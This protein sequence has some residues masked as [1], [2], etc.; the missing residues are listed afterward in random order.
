MM[1]KFKRFFFGRLFPC[2]LTLTFAAAVFLFLSLFLP[3]ALL[4]AFAVERAFTA[5]VALLS[6]RDDELPEERT[7]WLVLMLLLPWTGA[8]ARLL[9]G[10][11]PPKPKIGKAIQMNDD[12]LSSCASIAS[13]SNLFPARYRFAKYFPFGKDA[14]CSYLNDLNEAKKYIFLEYYII[15]PG[16]FWDSVLKILERKAKNGVTVKLIFDGFGCARSPRTFQRD[17]MRRGIEAH[18][19]RKLPLFPKR[20]THRR[21]HRKCTV[22]DGIIAYTGGINLADEYVGKQAPFG[23]WKDDM[24]RLQGEIAEEFA[25]MFLARFSPELLQSRTRNCKRKTQN[26]FDANEKLTAKFQ[27]K[28]QT[29]N[30]PSYNPLSE[31]RQNE[32]AEIPRFY[33]EYP[34][35]KHKHGEPSE[36]NPSYNPPSE[37]RQNEQA[38]NPRFY[39]ENLSPKHKH[40]EPSENNPSYNPPS[41]YRQNEQAEIPRFYNEYPSPKHKH[42]EPSENNFAIPFCDEA[43]GVHNRVCPD[44]FRSLFYKAKKCIFLYTPYLI[45]DAETERALC[46][47]ATSGV[48]VRILIPHVPDKKLV[49][50]LSRRSARRLQAHGV[51]VREY[52]DGFLHAK[53]LTQDG[54]Y[55]V[56]G[57]Y[58]LDFRSFYLQSECA[59]L[60]G[61]PAVARTVEEDFLTTWKMSTP[62][63]PTKR[64]ERFFGAIAHFFAPLF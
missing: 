42:G 6:L 59:V 52:T 10:I 2:S 29:E 30:N 40:G 49:F 60:L 38:E 56:V 16:I 63:P 51:C 7:R 58:N 37:H 41:E 31:Y 9:R 15:K 39:N 1:R 11:Y 45:P 21:D 14:F 43:V 61:D 33:N 5:V 13:K 23:S 64:G 48:D 18:C 55:A 25:R 12:V 36:N 32:Q 3:K 28:S 17:L 62:V 27:R 8:V 26:C 46:V 20:A 54:R 35:P 4:P 24:V 50:L 47:A 34:S 44:L 57:S 22:I 19:Y 53:S